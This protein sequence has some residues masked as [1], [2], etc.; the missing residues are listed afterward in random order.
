ML[1]N[2]GKGVFL[3]IQCHS[4]FL[5]KTLLC[6]VVRIRKNKTLLCEVVRIRKSFIESGERVFLPE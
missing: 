4:F 3:A 5:Y 2:S 1:E 6:E